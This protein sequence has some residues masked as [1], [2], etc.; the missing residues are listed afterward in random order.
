MDNL[1]E[2]NVYSLISVYPE[3]T[4]VADPNAGLYP[5]MQAA[6]MG[7]QLSI[8][9]ILLRALLAKRNIQ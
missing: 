4:C 8:T 1:E 5:Y 3:S 9:Y 2:R 7:Q 6:L